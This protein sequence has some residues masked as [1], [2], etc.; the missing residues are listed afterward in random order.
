MKFLCNVLSL[1][2]D[3]LGMTNI[4]GPRPLHPRFSPRACRRSAD[5]AAFL[6]LFSGLAFINA[7]GS[8]ATATAAAVLSVLFAVALVWLLLS[9]VAAWL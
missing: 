5:G 1:L 7:S 4:F 2:C 9:L 3:V 6:G 8:P